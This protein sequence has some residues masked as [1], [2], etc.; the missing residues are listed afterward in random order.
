MMKPATIIT[1]SKIGKKSHK[2]CGKTVFD[3]YQ[4]YKDRVSDSGRCVYYYCAMRRK[5]KCHARLIVDENG[6]AKVTGEH[7][8]DRDPPSVEA[9]LVVADMIEK[10]SDGVAPRQVL[11]SC[12]SN[13]NFG[14]LTRLPTE[15][16]SLR[17]IR[18]KRAS[19]GF[20][21][22]PEPKSLSE[23]LI[24][25]AISTL[26]GE[27]MML[28]DS[29]PSD[30]ERFFMFGSIRTLNY[31]TEE[32][33][34]HVDGTFT[35]PHT[36][37]QIWIIHAA[38]KGG[39][40]PCAFFLLPKK[41]AAVYRRALQALRHVKPEAQPDLVVADF[42]LAERIA[43]R[44]EYN[45][46]THGCYF[47]LSQSVFG[48]AKDLGLPFFYAHSYVMLTYV[49]ALWTLSFV[50]TVDVP[51]VF[52]LVRAAAVVDLAE[53][54]DQYEINLLMELY[55]YFERYYVRQGARF[56]ANMW[57]WFDFKDCT[58]RSNNDAEAFHKQFN[59]GIK[60][61]KTAVGLMNDIVPQVIKE[62]GL[63]E[64]RGER[65][66]IDPKKLHCEI[67]VKEARILNQ[68]ET[69]ANC[70]TDSDFIR[71]VLRMVELLV[72]LQRAK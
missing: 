23:I 64:T 36:L 34:W 50:P 3:G 55:D 21:R 54:H 49:R 12:Q 39:A 57:N 45:A 43:F 28:Y 17:T 20:A 18:K 69:F 48:C 47:H 61:R 71:Y 35:V 27:Q 67:S 63:A 46:P 22:M 68:M 26:H 2:P 52:G 66:R 4:Y 62:I 7:V 53:I 8:D 5:I 14:A 38:M 41:S 31:L 24:P 60:G 70:A 25:P 33:V 9:A 29:G 1:S 59:N 40:V 58:V 6:D 42:E 10:A 15:E 16:S 19:S 11:L 56:P 30:D 37:C 13:L 44:A 32:R 65:R 72:S 51:R